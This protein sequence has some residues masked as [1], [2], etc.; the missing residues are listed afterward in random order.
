[1]APGARNK[2]D[3]PVFEPKVFR[4][5]MF[6]IEECTCNI[7]GTFL[8]PQSFDAR[9]LAPSVRSCKGP[10]VDSTANINCPRV[11][12]NAQLSVFVL[13]SFHK[14]SCVL[15]LLR[16]PGQN[17]P[18]NYKIRTHTWLKSMTY[19]R[20]ENRFRPVFFWAKLSTDVKMDVTSALKEVT[21]HI[22]QASRGKFVYRPGSLG[23]ERHAECVQTCFSLSINANQSHICHDECWM[24]NNEKANMNWSAGK[25]AMEHEACPVRVSC[26]Q[27]A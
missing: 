2:C 18:S 4:E 13:K 22:F 19:V 27:L 5:Q 24:M 10:R 7:F 21:G 16:I 6:C 9:T 26:L 23:A 20:D 3:D 1:M 11:V 17:R 12:N 14:L 25:M 15:L 8:R